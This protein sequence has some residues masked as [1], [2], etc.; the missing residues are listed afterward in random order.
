LK[1]RGAARPPVGAGS[2]GA[3]I[4]A[5]ALVAALLGCS[6]GPRDGRADEASEPRGSGPLVVLVWFDD[7]GLD[8]RLRGELLPWLPDRGEGA[9]P[10]EG[11]PLPGS[12]TAAAAEVLSGAPV[13]VH[14]VVSARDFGAHRLAEGAAQQAFAV[15]LAQA[16]VSSSAVCAAPQLAAEWTGFDAGFEHYTALGEGSPRRSARPAAVVAALDSVPPGGEGAQF[17]LLQVSRPPD[18]VLPEVAPGWSAEFA[19]RRAEWA[20]ELGP[21]ETELLEAELAADDLAAVALRLGRRRGSA[22]QAVLGRALDRLW[23]DELERAL[24]PQL[25]ARTRERGRAVRVAWLASDRRGPEPLAAAGGLDAPPRSLEELDSWLGAAFAGLGVTVP[26]A[27]ANAPRAPGPVAGLELSCGIGPALRLELRAAEPTLLGVTVEALDGGQPA[28]WIA[29]RRGD[30]L[31]V[32]LPELPARAQRLR[33]EFALRATPVALGLVRAGRGLDPQDLWFGERNAL[34]AGALQRFEPSAEPWPEDAVA[35]LELRSGPAGSR[36]TAPGGGVPAARW[37]PWPPDELGAR[38]GAG[39]WALPGA[40]PLALALTLDGEPVS[41]D[42]LSFDGR[43]LDRGESVWVLPGGAD[44]EGAR[45]LEFVPLPAEP[46][47]GAVH[48]RRLGPRF[49][50]APPPTAEQR[51]FVAR[52]PDRE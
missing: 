22:A 37:L 38:I 13:A 9:A 25:A 4:V 32:E 29:A 35:A 43:A 46:R 10:A 11:W 31:S 3:R 30:R 39:P 42:Q 44:V 14:G 21:A 33:V 15:R 26:A 45:A 16:G 40:V 47:P 7:F 23:L 49:A 19:Q 1:R 41:L 34:A 5:V 50:E 20:P 36:L 52:L 48:L 8:P 17:L 27:P 28:Q 2:C 6:R 51:Q 24:G 12:L 18:G